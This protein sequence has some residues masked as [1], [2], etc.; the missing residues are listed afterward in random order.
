MN[1]VAAPYTYTNTSQ[2]AITML[3]AQIAKNI[4]TNWKASL[5]VLNVVLLQHNY[6]LYIITVVW[7]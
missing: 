7:Y 1:A 5:N 4:T 2:M 3:A 6:C